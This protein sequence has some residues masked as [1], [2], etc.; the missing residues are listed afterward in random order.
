MS[1]LILAGAPILRRGWRWTAQLH[2][3]LGSNTSTGR[4]QQNRKAHHGVAAMVLVITPLQRGQPG[5]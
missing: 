4:A 5:P 1:I 3:M 2:T